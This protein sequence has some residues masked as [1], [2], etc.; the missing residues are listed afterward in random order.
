MVV[1][2]NYD[3]KAIKELLKEIGQERYKCALKD[4]GLENQPPINMKGFYIEFDVKTEN[5]GLYY[6]YPSNVETFIMDVLGYWRLPDK[7]W[8][9]IRKV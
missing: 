6:K 8:E 4:E 3:T 2:K 7:G 9:M 1:F 5:I